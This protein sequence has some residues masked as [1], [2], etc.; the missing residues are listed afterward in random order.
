MLFG[1]PT[2]TT[3]LVLGSKSKKMSYCY[4]L[5]R[6]LGSNTLEEGKVKMQSPLV[7]SHTLSKSRKELRAFFSLF[8][9][10]L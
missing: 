6:T 7:R 4:K 1:P 2:D 10:F 5:R 3:R 8:G 9:D